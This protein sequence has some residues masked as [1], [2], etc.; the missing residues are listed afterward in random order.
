MCEEQV[1]V[2]F[3]GKW[4]EFMVRYEVKR[5]FLNLKE[6]RAKRKYGYHK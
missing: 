6:I 4:K 2:P 1:E 5:S 3:P